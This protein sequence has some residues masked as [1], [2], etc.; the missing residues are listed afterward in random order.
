MKE[1]LSYRDKKAFLGSGDGDGLSNDVPN[2]PQNSRA[3]DLGLQ[4]PHGQAILVPRPHPQHGFLFLLPQ[5]HREET[6]N[7]NGGY[8]SLSKTA[9]NSI[10]AM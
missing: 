5:L 3:D 2:S 4:W 8:W 7:C 6:D 9:T 10:R 1:R